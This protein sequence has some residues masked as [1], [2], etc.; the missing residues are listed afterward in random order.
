MD[1]EQYSDLLHA[2]AF[3]CNLGEEE[4]DLLQ[5]TGGIWFNS[6][7][8]YVLDNQEN[9][10][11][12]IFMYCIF[13]MPPPER[14]AEVIRMLLQE[15]MGMFPYAGPTFMI[16]PEDGNVVLACRY[17]LATLTPEHLAGIFESVS[18]EALKWRQTFY[19]DDAPTAPADEAA[20]NLNYA[21]V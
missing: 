6:V 8:F 13:G 17:A 16:N 20:A 19:L 10:S 9:D 18:Q 5:T 14:E 1:N 7:F 2:L 11:D 12:D 15:N 4:S 21:F 3:A